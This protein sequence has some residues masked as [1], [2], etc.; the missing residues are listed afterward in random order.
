VKVIYNSERH[1]LL[2]SPYQ[3]GIT[4]ACVYFTG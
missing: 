4:L 3:A 2:I 1:F